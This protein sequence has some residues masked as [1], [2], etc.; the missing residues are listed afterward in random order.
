M[1][2][3]VKVALKQFE[4]ACRAHFGKFQ[5]AVFSKAAAIKSVLGMRMIIEVFDKHAVLTCDIRKA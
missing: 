1:K 3:Y 2:M 5:L 4:P